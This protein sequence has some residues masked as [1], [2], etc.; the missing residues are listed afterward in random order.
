MGGD[1]SIRRLIRF[2]IGGEAGRSV[3]IS[4]GTTPTTFGGAGMEK[5]VGGR[6]GRSRGRKGGGGGSRR[7][8][9]RGG[10]GGAQ[11]EKEEGTGRQKCV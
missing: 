8:V 10:G 6:L 4:A 9:K 1:I 5:A 2:R 3:L 11:M 7:V